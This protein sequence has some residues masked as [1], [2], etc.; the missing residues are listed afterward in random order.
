MQNDLLHEVATPLQIDVEGWDMRL[1]SGNDD[2]Y[3]RYV[4]CLRRYNR[5]MSFW[6]HTCWY[7][8][9]PIDGP[10][11]AW[12]YVARPGEFVPFLGRVAT[13]WVE[14]HHYPDCPDR[15][16]EYEEEMREMQ[17]REDRARA[18]AERKAA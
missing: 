11:E 3:K 2:T 10:Y 13:F 16:D 7:C 9:K 8:N 1:H 17:E 12:V 6:Y 18:A 4:R 14:K 5:W 15:L